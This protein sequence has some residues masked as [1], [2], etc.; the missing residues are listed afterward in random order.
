MNGSIRINARRLF[1][2]GCLMV[3][4]SYAADFTWLGSPASGNWNESD[5]NWTGAASV[6][7][8]APINNAT[9]GVSNIKTITADAV[10][11]KNLT[12][13]ADGY[14]IGGGPF[15]MY[16]GPTVGAGLSALL[17]ATVTNNAGLCDKRGAGTLV[18][19]SGFSRT[20]SFSTLRVSEGLLQITGGTH[21]IYTND[22]NNIN[23]GFDVNYGT[24][25]VSGGKVRQTSGGYSAVRGTLVITNGVV[26]LSASRET[27]NA[28]NGAGTTTVGGNGLLDVTQ[29]R[30][31]QTQLLPVSQN[32]VNV[33]TGGVIRINSFTIDPKASPLG[34]V[35]FNGGAVVAKASTADFLGT[36]A[37]QWLNGISAK[38]LAGGAV[39]DTQANSVSIKQPLVSGATSDGGLIKKGSGTLS[40]RGTN[41]FNGTTAIQGGVLN[42]VDDNNL[43]AVP[44]SPSTNFLF[45][46]KSTLQSGATHSLAAHR[47]FWITNAVLAAFDTQAYTQT[48]YSTVM[49][50]ETNSM[51]VKQGTGMLVLDP[52]PTA[53]NRFG[54]LQV[55]NGIL[56]I[57][58]GTNLV[59]CPNSGQ[60]APG[61]WIPSGTLLVAGGV[62][63][64]TALTYVN[65]DGGTLLVTNGLVDT[66]SCNELLNSIGGTA[67]GFGYTT[68]SGSGVLIANRVR[69]SQNNGDPTNSVVTVNTGGVLRVSSFYIDIGASQKGMLV[70]N[71]GTVEARSD[72]VDFL[73]TTATL[74]GNNNDRWLNNIFVRVREGG[75]IFNTAGYD[76]SIKQPLVPDVASDGG[77][78]KRG[79]G[80]LTLLN[81]NTYNGATSVEG[82]TLKL[83]VLTNTLLTSGSAF[84]SSNAVFDINTKVQTL[85]GLGGSGTVTNNGSLT[86]V[87]LVAPGGT[88]GIGTLTLASACSLSGE[89]CVDVATNGVCDRLY[90]QGNLSVTNLALTVAD[91]R[92]LSTDKRYL[93]ATYTGTLTKPFLSKT[94]PKHWS[95]RYDTANSRI[96]LV[97][98][99][100]LI[101][102]L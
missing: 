3:G 61:L 42:I 49:C 77:L 4:M 9:F 87:G 97:Y 100:T 59:T 71:G 15:L 24:M 65:V 17:I 98:L 85:A 22:L 39:I 52:G 102:L 18:L 7:T 53:V 34:M 45:L 35:N 67:P 25:L 79:A 50:A 82:G 16:G 33:N 68:V 86:V 6:W 12:I 72:M 43:G 19:D 58:S 41:T 60:N 76:I 54:T 26:D 64:T 56:V 55:T 99:G 37:T 91:T 62:L 88:N 73:G 47:T 84:V 36:G 80:M 94:L 90:V 11:L 96:Y 57:A 29:I 69:I 13:S 30:I 81:T 63:K 20:N 8:S 14:T 40:L 5:T 75:A 44:S 2:L 93:I 66:T 38:I 23:I 46:S 74:V 89:F 92:L 1:L 28:F 70:L 48:V 83:G 95:V 31:S 101:T 78:I 27:L 51:F 21:E 32:A 10:T